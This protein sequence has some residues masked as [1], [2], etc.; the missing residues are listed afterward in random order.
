MTG[1]RAAAAEEAKL[2][3]E[4]RA[5]NDTQRLVLLH[6]LETV[7]TATPLALEEEPT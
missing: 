2:L 6:F 4:F 1:K 5:L 3:E 7:R